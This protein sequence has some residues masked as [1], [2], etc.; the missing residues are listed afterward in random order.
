M[1]EACRICG[2]GATH[3]IA[4]YVDVS[5]EVE[6]AMDATA[7]KVMAT[8]PTDAVLEQ[9]PR[10][11]G[12]VWQAIAPILGTDDPYAE[13][14]HHYNE[15]T[16]ALYDQATAQVRAADDPAHLALRISAVG[17]LID[18]GPGIEFDEGKVTR[19]VADAPN[20]T[21]AVD[22]SADLL[23][24]ALAASS[25]VYVADNCGEVAFDKLLIAELRR[26][27]PRLAA[28]Y[29]VRDRPILNDVTLV[30][31]REAHMDDVA[32]VITNGDAHS[33]AGTVLP[34]TSQEFMDAF[35][36]ADIVIAKGQGN[37]ETLY[38]CDRDGVFFMLMA[39]CPFVARLCGTRQGDLV[40]ME[41]GRH[42]LDVEGAFGQ[43]AV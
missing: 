40:C 38:R 33:A 23:D 31:A 7:R 14:K 17:N 19:L 30:D 42:D 8:Y 35:L 10:S 21:F 39:K 32:H 11:M 5:H 4:R 20:R 12:E 13:V 1:F 2:I 36:G 37:L 16:L 3:S 43:A 9:N 29:V 28:T 24:R 22:D 27:N 15:V 34:H 25:L 26:E 41:K 6:D 18:F